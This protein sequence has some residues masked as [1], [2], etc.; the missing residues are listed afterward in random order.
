[1]NPG[2]SYRPHYTVTDYLQ[3]EG[4]WELWKGVAVAMTPSPFGRHGMMLMRLG[5]ALT[6]AVDR[7]ECDAS[8]LAEI[9]WIVSPDTVIRPDISVVCGPP[10]E[11]H[12]ESSPALV[13]EVLSEST[14]E[15]DLLH[16]RE[17]Y[18]ENAVPWYII[19]DPVEQEITI[20]QL[21]DSGKYEAVETSEECE[22]TLCD[23]CKTTIDLRWSRR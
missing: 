12:I 15:R 11:G 10:P 4:D 23:H 9:D 21:S 13:V 3:W 2:V 7:G 8:V 19:G 16:K 14:R 5:T 6:N 20:L 1:M 18:Q 17:L 22:I